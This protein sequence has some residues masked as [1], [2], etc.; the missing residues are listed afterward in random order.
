MLAMLLRYC[1]PEQTNLPRAPS[2]FYIFTDSVNVKGRKAHKDDQ[3]KKNKEDKEGEGRGIGV[4]WSWITSQIWKNGGA[5][6]LLSTEK[7]EECECQY[8]KIR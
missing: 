4:C 2:A 5:D 3:K 6:V 1:G 7:A 8:M